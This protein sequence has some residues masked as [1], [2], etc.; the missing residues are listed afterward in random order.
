MKGITVKEAKEALKYLKQLAP[1]R[2]KMDDD[3]EMSLR[4]AIFFMAD[5]LIQKTKRGCTIK[6]L[7]KGLSARNIEIKPGTL[8]RY[9][10]EYQDAQKSGEPAKEKP[11][12][13]SD[14]TA[15]KADAKS[16]PPPQSQKAP[17]VHD[18]KPSDGP[19]GSPAPHRLTT[20]PSSAAGVNPSA[21]PLSSMGVSNGARPNPKSDL[22][23][24]I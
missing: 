7:V 6:E 23:D 18:P 20:P 22:D 15:G 12:K 2:P 4:E 13:K 1:A 14:G 3:L 9:L 24:L 8:N 10:N 17:H 16:D 5:D 11:E 21:T 19:G